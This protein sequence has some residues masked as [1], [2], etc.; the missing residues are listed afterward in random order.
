MR[1]DFAGGKSERN[2][3]RLEEMEDSG[4]SNGLCAALYPKFATEVVDVP[5]HRVHAQHKAA[6]DLAVGGALQQQ[7]QDLALTL[8]Q[9]LRKHIMASRGGEGDPRCAAPQRRRGE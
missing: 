7:A 1:V 6:G 3:T 5:L 2:S 8:G 4:P 9:R